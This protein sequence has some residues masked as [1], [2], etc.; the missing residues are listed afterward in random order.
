DDR[1]ADGK[2]QAQATE[3][4]PCPSSALFDQVEDSWEQVGLDADAPIDDLDHQPGPGRFRTR[5][6][7][8][9][10][11]DRDP[12]TRGRELDRILEEV[13]E[14]LLEPRRV[15]IE[16]VSFGLELRDQCEI[17]VVNLIGTDRQDEVDLLVGID[18]LTPQEQLASLDPR[19]VQQVIDQP[20]LQLDI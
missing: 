15:R 11:P 19:Q 9:P 18:D 5:G 10:R 7:A 3:P 6:G 17:R 1:A 8:I 14:D 12:S 13:P 2:P 20:G 16:M 4:S